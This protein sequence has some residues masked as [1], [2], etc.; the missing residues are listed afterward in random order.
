[1]ADKSQSSNNRV[2]FI[3]SNQSKI[4][5]KLEYSLVQSGMTNLKPILENKTSYKK[6][7]FATKVFCF[8]IIQKELKD[9]DK[10]AD[11]KKYVAKINL[12]YNR[13]T[14]IGD[15]PFIKD[16]NNF[17]Y[18]FAFQDYEGWTGKTAPPFYIRYTE[19]E[20]IQLFNE[21]LR[22][23][24]VKQGD[25]L[26][27]NL[28]SD[29]QIM[30]KGKK[31]FLDFYIEILKLC[32]AKLEVKMHLIMFKLERVLL[33]QKMDVKLYSKF[34][35]IIE[36]K[37]DII[38][39]HCKA[40]EN[41][42]RYFKS[43]YTLLLY[44]RANYEQEKIPLLLAKRDLWK[45]FID[46]LPT[47][48]KYFPNLE[49]PNE[50]IIEMIK[51]EPNT[52]VAIK[53]ALSFLNSTEKIL[54][55]INDNCEIIYD[56]CTKENQLIEMSEMVN[57]K[58]TD[59]LNK[60][61]D[62]IKKIIQYQME[63][64]KQFISFGVAFWKT[65]IQYNDKKNLKN[66]IL[67]NKAIMFYKKTDKNL[68][69]NQFNLIDIIHNNGI[70]AIEKGELKN[71]DLL[72]FIENEDIYFTDKRFES[73][74]KRPLTILNGIDLDK[75]DEKFYERWE[76]SNIFKIYSFDSYSFKKELVKKIDDM[77][78]FGKL[79]KLFNY[80]NDKILDSEVIPL[81]R[82][83]FKNIIKTYKMETCPNFIKDIALFIYVIDKKTNEAKKFMEKTIETYIKS[84]QTISDIYLHLATN[85]NDIS[86]EAIDSITNYFTKN[87]DRL[88]GQSFLFLLKLNNKKLVKS[89]LNKIDR[90]VIKEE[91]ILSQEKD[92]DS[93][94]LLEGI[95]KEKLLDK[96]PEINETKYLIN[97]F[98]LGNSFID[99][100]KNG[101]IS[102]SGIYPFLVKNEKKD[103]LKERLKILFFNNQGD[104]DACIKC[105]EDRFKKI[106]Q[107][108]F[109][110][111]KLLGVLKEFY[112]VKHQKNIKMIEDFEKQIKSGKLNEIEKPAN[113]SKFETMHQILPDLDDK[114]K[115]KQS[116][117]FLHFFQTRKANSIKKEDE[118]FEEALKDFE[119][120]KG[121]FEE[122]WI[123]KIDESIVKE[124]YKALKNMK[125]IKVELKRI[126]D[127]YK[128]NNIEDL[129]FD[130]LEDEIKIFSKKEEIFQTVNSCL[131]FIS[132]LG[133]KPTDFS[134]SLNKL[135]DDISKNISVDKIKEYGKSLVKF[136]INILEQKPE[137]KDYLTI[138]NSL[139]SKKGSLKFILTLTEED[140]RTLQEL[141]SES[142][143]TFL[144][145]A[146]IQDMT[147]CSNFIHSFGNIKD[148][149]TDQELIS[150]L[151]EKVPQEKNI[152]AF[153][154]QYTKNFGEIQELLSQKLDKSQA[155]L[156]QI[157]DI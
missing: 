90:F 73:K 117:F 100:S 10:T 95:E 43:F 23:L 35:E 105:F 51:K 33:P 72:D 20:Q 81:L 129:Y 76:K 62:E 45:Y 64:K 60:V 47:N 108:I 34:L 58:N 1:M 2:F 99:K 65:Y 15:V 4:D 88:K 68:K 57:P 110:V 91:E 5:Q 31:F 14:F 98:Q 61:I 144:T 16:R 142:E 25:A 87:K 106:T 56:C 96:Y 39:R 156:K 82:E 136:G 66:L 124:C 84:F 138:L 36:K 67:I 107:A 6:E 154:I 119:K 30:I 11:K 18:T 75:A 38:I 152:S 103:I 137:D 70:E 123:N 145:G 79:F 130:K 71:E 17:I 143:N 147:K 21:V 28:V 41:T 37:P 7:E 113:K 49:I 104:I 53:G 140:C 59:D 85:F 111:R 48:H 92:I 141:V 139:Y 150:L 54:S 63:K 24:K 86:K 97:T 122:N 151:I 40:T 42:D 29:S 116:Q 83:K 77:K 19:V 94:A 118:I 148:V 125:S 149:K 133:A 8:D 55:T 128:L 69:D 9:K 146:E 32:Y 112:E 121:L 46:I 101:E 26:S 115:L 89:V 27:L 74:G 134:S 120:L 78:D 102:Y 135:R 93:F 127:Y 80:K 50:L 126:K 132:E 157:K 131:Y 155:T 3:T 22:K 44:F 109:Y 13:C 52:F 12:K 114:C 153:F